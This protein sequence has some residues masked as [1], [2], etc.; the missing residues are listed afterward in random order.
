[1]FKK[2]LNFIML[3]LIIVGFVI[4]IYFSCFSKNQQQEKSTN[5]AI[6]AMLQ[7]KP[8]EVTQVFTFGKC[9]NFSGKLAGIS[10]DNFES[11][12]LY[13]TDANGFEKNYKLDAKVE[14]ETLYLSTTSQINTGLILDE[15]TPGEY[16][17]LVRIKMNNHVNPKY[18][19]LSNHSEND[20]IEYF[21][22]TKENTNRKVNINFK[23][24]TYDTH[25]YAYLSLDITNAEKPEDVYDIVIDAGHG[26]KDIGEKSGSHTEADITLSYAKRLKE[27]L[28]AQGL[29]VKLTRDDVNTDTYTSTNMYDEKWQ[30]HNRLSFQSK[31]Y[32]V[33]AH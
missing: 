3:I 24:K 25:E 32:A 8:I 12:K 16:I 21:T 11:A 17:L 5:D 28:E 6:F 33:F 26:G 10:K 7:T 20:D 13:V 29:K 18:Y 14:E 27:R 31:I 30:N 4:G 1:M 22:I 9:F 19:S 15:L 2:I 23:S